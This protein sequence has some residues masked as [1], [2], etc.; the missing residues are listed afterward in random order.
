[1]LK[2]RKR[3]KTPKNVYCFRDLEINNLLNEIQVG[4]E[5]VHI[6]L[7]VCIALQPHKDTLNLVKAIL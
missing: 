4:N 7:V 6:H 2:K 5:L 3:K 1:M